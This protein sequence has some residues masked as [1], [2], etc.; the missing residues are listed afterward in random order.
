MNRHDVCHMWDR[1]RY[2]QK[3]CCFFLLLLLGIKAALMI[4]FSVATNIVNK[5]GNFRN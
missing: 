5:K 2:D 3:V 1:N 4:Y